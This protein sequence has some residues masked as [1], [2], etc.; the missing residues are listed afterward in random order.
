MLLMLKMLGCDLDL[1][2][3]LE[4]RDSNGNEIDLAALL[5][6]AFVQ[7]PSPK[8]VVDEETLEALRRQAK[9]GPYSASQIEAL[10]RILPPGSELDISELIKKGIKPNDQFIDGECPTFRGIPIFVKEK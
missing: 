5:A 8:I 3:D 9:G 6:Q 2:A 4:L 7:L 1:G 10:K